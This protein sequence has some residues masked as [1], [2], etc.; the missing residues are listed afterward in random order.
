[1]KVILI[2]LLLIILILTLFLILSQ[3]EIS[4]INQRL[5]QID[6][7]SNQL[8]EISLFNPAIN[9]LT[10]TI[11]QQIMEQRTERIATFNQEQE[12]KETISEISHDLRTPLT[13]MIGYLQLLEREELSTEQ[14]EAVQI[15]LEKSLAMKSLTQ[16]FFELSYYESKTVELELERFNL[17][18]LLI[19][20]MLK[21]TATFEQR[22]IVPTLEVQEDC[23]ILS[24]AKLV[25]RILQNVIA[26]VLQHGKDQLRVE[27]LQQ[28]QT[29]LTFSNKYES[30]EPIDPQKIFQRFYV[31][32]YARNGNGLGLAI[33]ELL[34]KQLAID[35]TAEVSGE[36]F[37]IRLAFPKK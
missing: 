6:L 2:V 20:E 22:L 15:L 24:D 27:L 10:E 26:N 34:S 13:S 25:T 33:V 14:Q 3:R 11:N 35:V 5:K 18:Q 37:T 21:E 36:D 31:A 9:Q 16:S 32:S 28:E 7:N 23:F 19:D 1:M 17:S 4:K 12:L 8:V 30:A 29:I